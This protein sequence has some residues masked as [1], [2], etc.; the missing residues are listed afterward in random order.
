MS[1]LSDWA[2]WVAI[3]ISIAGFLHSFLSG[4]SKQNDERFGVIAGKVDAVEDRVT[5]IEGELKHLP[6]KNATHRL[7]L[8]LAEMRTELRGV[9]ES[10]K[11]IKAMA[12]R[13]QEAALETLVHR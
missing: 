10:M 4:R 5:R 13:I 11:P 9:T 7:E 1:N 12:E 8:T 3:V 6:D 2:P